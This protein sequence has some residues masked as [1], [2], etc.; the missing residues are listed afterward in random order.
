MPP[1]K[2]GLV[3]CSAK[4]ALRAVAAASVE[5]R[6][7]FMRP[8]YLVAED[9]SGAGYQSTVM[10]MGVVRRWEWALGVSVVMGGKGRETEGFWRKGK[11][12]MGEKGGVEGPLGVRKDHW[13]KMM[14][15]RG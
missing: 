4:L 15:E 12:L 10:D 1:K 2:P 14:G 11:G 3:V 6:F 8:L 7:W 5:L 9:W 13:C